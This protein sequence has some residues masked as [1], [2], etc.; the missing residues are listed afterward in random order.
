MLGRGKI[1][2]NSFKTDTASPRRIL[3]LMDKFAPG[4]SSTAILQPE[5]NYTI[6]FEINKHN[7]LLENELRKLRKQ[8]DVNFD[9]YTGINKKDKYEEEAI[10]LRRPEKQERLFIE[11]SPRDDLEWAYIRGMFGLPSNITKEV[12]EEETIET[13]GDN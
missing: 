13:I 7:M 5:S 4:L 12:S 6:S 9:F 11:F 1:K 2:E 10:N 3:E 8:N